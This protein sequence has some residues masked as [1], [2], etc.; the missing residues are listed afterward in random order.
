MIFAC[1]STASNDACL[2]PLPLRR[3]C[4]WFLHSLRRQAL[5]RAY[6]TCLYPEFACDFC[7]R[8]DGRRRCV[9][10]HFAFAQR[11][12]CDFC[13]HCNG[14]RQSVLIPLAFV[15]SLP[16]VFAR[17]ATASN[18]ACLHPLPLRRVCRWF[19]HALQRLASMRSV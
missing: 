16:V 17:I 2:Y 3:V 7:M 6:T 13:M 9:L 10:M 19:L 14:K 8:Y 18:D 4:R 15:Q 12:A 1:I 11:F 5:M